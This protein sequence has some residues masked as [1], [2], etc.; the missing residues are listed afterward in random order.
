MA[1]IIAP[2]R[3]TVAVFN[4]LVVNPVSN[5][6]CGHYHFYG[7]YG[8]L[9]QDYPY[10]CGNTTTRSMHSGFCRIPTLIIIMQSYTVN[11][12]CKNC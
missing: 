2:N 11:K 7:Q 10:R 4:N 9:F 1:T 6:P 5:C 3:I 12:N 8:H